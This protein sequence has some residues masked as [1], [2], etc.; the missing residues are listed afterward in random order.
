MELRIC[1]VRPIMFE[2]DHVEA[3]CVRVLEAGRYSYSG[4]KAGTFSLA[5]LGFAWHMSNSLKP[6]ISVLRNP[7]L[8]SFHDVVCSRA[9]DIKQRA[10]IGVESVEHREDRAPALASPRSL[11]VAAPRP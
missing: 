3:K 11:R 6:N 5:F 10:T 4:M 2:A 9:I 1:F 7:L 8:G